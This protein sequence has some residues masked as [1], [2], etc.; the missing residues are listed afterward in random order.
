[1]PVLLARSNAMNQ[2]FYILNWVLNKQYCRNIER[3]DKYL[4]ASTV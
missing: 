3:Q 2:K 1:M 4:W